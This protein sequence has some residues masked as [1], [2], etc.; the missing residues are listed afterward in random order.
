MANKVNI[1]YHKDVDGFTSAALTSMLLESWGYEPIIKTPIDYPLARKWRSGEMKPL[2]PFSVVDWPFYNPESLLHADH[3][4]TKEPII[5]S[6]K[7]KYL[8]INLDAKS[9]ASII[10]DKL[11]EFGNLNGCEL[12]RLEEMVRWCDII[13]S[14]SYKTTDKSVDD[15]LEPKRFSNEPALVVSKALEAARIGNHSWLWNYLA[16]SLAKNPSY[17][18]LSKNLL[19]SYLYRRAIN[20]QTEAIK[21]LGKDKSERSSRKYDRQHQILTYSIDDNKW[22]RYGFARSFPGAV[23]AVGIRKTNQGAILVMTKNPWKENHKGINAGEFLEKYRNG[24]GRDFGGSAFFPV[25]M[26]AVEAQEDIVK[27][28]KEAN[29]K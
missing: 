14:A 8:C 28:I 7:T 13:D 24:G 19:I 6:E 29:K 12:G 17:E 3:H 4:K 1:Y 2:E 27:K 5:K 20:Q 25:L 22:S 26:D 10:L 23:W 21:E 11:K 9:C 15:V 16:R 18:H